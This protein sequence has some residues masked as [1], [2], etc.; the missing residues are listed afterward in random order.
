[1]QEQLIDVENQTWKIWNNHTAG[2]STLIHLRGEEQFQSEIGRHLFRW[3]NGQLLLKDLAYGSEWA[4][5]KPPAHSFAR[6]SG[7]KAH[8]AV[9]PLVEMTREHRKA[10]SLEQG[11]EEHRQALRNLAHKVCQHE[12]S[13]QT[14]SSAAFEPS[15]SELRSFV[16]SHGAPPFNLTVNYF[17]S[18]SDA[19]QWT[20]F[21][22]A[23]FRTTRL[24]L[25]CVSYLNS[26]GELDPAL[27][28]ESALLD[29]LAEYADQLCSAMAYFLGQVN[30]PGEPQPPDPFQC[31]GSFSRAAYALV[32]CNLI[33]ATPE[34]DV[35]R[36]GLRDWVLDCLLMAG[37]VYGLRQAYAFHQF[38]Q[39]QVQEQKGRHHFIVKPGSSTGA[40][41][42]VTT[43]S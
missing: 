42:K 2:I 33:G 9:V 17:S 32:S 25:D 16:S 20:N 13:L 5:K 7:F 11:T 12:R 39:T 24:Y 28:E 15:A 3:I 23:K 31:R 27:A 18:Y 37:S 19:V 6:E 34:I 21:W 35:R 40:A 22:T 8:N 36:P 14:L 38:I 30:N 41:S 29:Q 1:M 43:P 10:L 26:Y 4:F